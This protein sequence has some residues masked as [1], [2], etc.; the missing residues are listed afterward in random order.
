MGRFNATK[1]VYPEQFDPS[2]DHRKYDP[3]LSKEGT[4][5]EVELVPI[6]NKTLVQCVRDHKQPYKPASRDGGKRKKFVIH[7]SQA[8]GCRRK[9]FFSVVDAK[10]D[11]RPPDPDLQRM[12][13]MGHQ[14][15]ER[16]QGYLFEAWKRSVGGVV[17]VWEDVKLKVLGIGASGELDGIIQ[18]VDWRYLVEIK[19][20][21]DSVY[22]NTVVPKQDWLWQTHIYMEGTGLRAAILLMECRNNGRMRQ[23]F[24]PWSDEVWD[25]IETGTLE[26]LA[27]IEGEEVPEKTD[28]RTE[29]YWCRYTELCKNPKM[30]Q[31]IDYGRVHLPQVT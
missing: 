12:F 2:A 9:V 31:R 8:A 11:M 14:A 26:V 13:A 5:P 15:H 25:T 18:I 19:T 6:I 10:E 17:R 22:K 7:P 23:F 16:I 21:S 4:P 30:Q 1:T 29:C 3:S 27:A 28:D 20:C 24:I